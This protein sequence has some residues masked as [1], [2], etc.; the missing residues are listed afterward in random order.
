MLVS[1]RSASSTTVMVALAALLLRSRSLWMLAAAT[2]AEQVGA[3]QLDR[4]D[5]SQEDAGPATGR[6]RQSAADR[7]DANPRA[8]AGLGLRRTVAGVAAIDRADPVH[9]V[10]ARVSVA[11]T[12]AA[13]AVNGPSLATVIKTRSRYRELPARWRR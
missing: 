4:D 8:A 7:V 2:L 1:A 9:E 13:I 5:G 3:A 6:Q 10:A 12:G 11:V